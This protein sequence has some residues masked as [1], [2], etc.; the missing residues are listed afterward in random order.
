MAVYLIVVEVRV[1]C[2]LVIFIRGVVFVGKFLPWLDL[3]RLAMLDDLGYLFGLVA[4]SGRLVQG[5]ISLELF[6]VENLI[7]GLLLDD[8]LLEIRNIVR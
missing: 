2:C 6:Y 8:F 3:L 7:H 1:R 4:L 5:L